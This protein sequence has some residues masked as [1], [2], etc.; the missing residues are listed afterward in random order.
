MLQPSWEG[1]TQKQIS[2]NLRIYIISRRVTG[3]NDE[4]RG[5]RNVFRRKGGVVLIVSKS[6]AL[7]S[8]LSLPSEGKYDLV[9]L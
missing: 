9:S 5:F 1:K 7:T 6:P 3:V 2:N 8:P 4:Y